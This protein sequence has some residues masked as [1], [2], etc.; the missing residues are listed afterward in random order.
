VRHGW[1]GVQRNP[2]DAFHQGYQLGRFDRD[3]PEEWRRGF[4]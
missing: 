4:R 2:R 3:Q 1:R